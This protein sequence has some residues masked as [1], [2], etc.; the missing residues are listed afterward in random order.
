VAAA[1]QEHG[2]EPRATEPTIGRGPS[3]ENPNHD[4]DAAAARAAE[5]KPPDTRNNPKTVSDATITENGETKP[6]TKAVNGDPPEGTVHHAEQRM[7][8]GAADN[9]ETVLAQSP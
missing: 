8:R 3:R 7:E 9:G 2:I 5:G 1:A 4:P 6:Y